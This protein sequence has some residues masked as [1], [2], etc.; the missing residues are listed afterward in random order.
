MSL[1]SVQ[2]QAFVAVDQQ[3][4]TPFTLSWQLR[5]ADDLQ[6][7]VLHCYLRF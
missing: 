7:I 3:A 4:R 2:R 5:L 1:T 6:A